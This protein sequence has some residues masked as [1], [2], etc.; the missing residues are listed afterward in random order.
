[1]RI[2]YLVNRNPR[3]SHSFIRREIHALEALG[4]E[5]V[6]FSLR[7]LDEELVDPADLRELELTRVV[8]DAGAVRHALALAAAALRRP[9]AL[10]RA[11]ALAVRLGWRSDRGLLR[12]LAYLAEA[13]LLARWLGQSPVDH[14]H[15][16]F[17]TNSAAVAALCHA[18]GGPPYSFTVHGSEFDKPEFLALGEKVRHAAFAVAVS[19]YGRAQLC[20]W[21]RDE[22][23][24]K[25]HVV[26]TGL[27]EDLLRTPHAPIPDAP[28]LVCVAR[29]VRLK[30]HAILL[31]AA[32]LLAAEGVRFELVLA[33]DGPYR[34][35]IVE[36]IRARGLE[37]RVKVAGMMS[38]AQ[39]RE[40]IQRARAM[41]LPSLSEGLPV[42]IMEALALGRPVVAT[43]ISGIPELVE[44]GSTGWLVPAGSAE[45][46]ARALR[47]ALE[48]PAA[49]LEEMGRRGASRVARRHDARREAAKL[50]ELVRTAG[51]ATG[52][53]AAEEEPPPRR[54]AQRS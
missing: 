44:P 27:D 34:A 14:V 49:R 46:L 52:A 30:G 37:D 54:A 21:A 2:A 39:V 13:A 8:L 36:M 25:I 42:V 24:D 9:A 53:D 43:A 11:L 4:H 22:D 5:V 12:H 38:A 29:L 20:R 15:A 45:P 32:S 1:L 40:A 7:P 48:A 17:G 33:G 50:V 10:A 3:A 28:R 6:R 41:V 18:L 51:R 31:E 19:S 16:H 23:W 26:H 35:R 47:Q